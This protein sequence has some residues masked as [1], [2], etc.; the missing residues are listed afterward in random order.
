M[1]D[2]K[3]V[4]NDVYPL[5]LGGGLL[6]DVLNFAL[7]NLYQYGQRLGKES[8][9]NAQ[10]L[11]RLRAGKPSN[12]S[13]S[14]LQPM[15]GPNVV[16]QISPTNWSNYSPEAKAILTEVF[17]KFPRL[18]ERVQKTRPDLHVSVLEGSDLTSRG[19]TGVMRSVNPYFDEIQLGKTQRIEG[20]PVSKTPVGDAINWRSLPADEMRPDLETT[21]HELQHHI[22]QPRLMQKGPADAADQATIGLLL[23]DLMFNKD[24]GSLNKRYS[25]Y[26]D[27]AFDPKKW[28]MP[29]KN[30]HS[31]GMFDFK[32]TPWSQFVGGAMADEGLAYLANN[33]INDPKLAILAEQ[34][35]VNPG[36]VMR[37]AAAQFI[38]P[39]QPTPAAPSLMDEVWASI[40]SMRDKL[41]GGEY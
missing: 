8:E 12:L 41:S 17:N 6:K 4:P 20:A 36:Q 28:N 23:K 40:N 9:S 7:N 33:A 14:A 10:A 31:R 32:E 19:A 30:P 37:P 3:Q 24:I 2:D 26:R 34:L 5:G 29:I 38:K 18:F 21:V 25:Q 13:T 22:N 27:A 39:S 16:G 15:I 11:E 1:A 35:G